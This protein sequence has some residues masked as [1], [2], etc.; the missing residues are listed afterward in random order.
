MPGDLGSQGENPFFV[1]Y[2]ESDPSTS[3][4]P[5]YLPGPKAKP[6][7]MVVWKLARDIDPTL[8]RHDRDY[9]MHRLEIDGTLTLLGQEGS[10]KEFQD[11]LKALVLQISGSPS[12]VV[13]KY[14]SSRMAQDE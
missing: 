1:G 13:S 3:Q 10:Q 2:H 14:L 6:V 11:R 5:L 4:R 12:R 7:D 9:L 8:T